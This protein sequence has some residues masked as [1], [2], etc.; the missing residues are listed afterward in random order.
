MGPGCCNGSKMCSSQVLTVF[1]LR[2]LLDFC[3]CTQHLRDIAGFFSN[4]VPTQSKNMK[5]DHCSLSFYKGIKFFLD[6]SILLLHQTS[7]CSLLARTELFA[8]SK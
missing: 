5:Y 8:H 6:F 1:S 2:F 4:I 7:L 3:P